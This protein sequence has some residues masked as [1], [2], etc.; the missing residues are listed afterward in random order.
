MIN[1]DTDV[2]KDLF[3]KVFEKVGNLQLNDVPLIY[4]LQWLMVLISPLNVTNEGF[5]RNNFPD[6]SKYFPYLTIVHY[7]FK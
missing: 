5:N 7:L 6:L 4:D 2:K 3:L 1:K